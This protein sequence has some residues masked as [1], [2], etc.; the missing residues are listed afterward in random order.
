MAD[1]PIV[2]SSRDSSLDGSMDPV[3]AELWSTEPPAAAPG[4]VSMPLADYVVHPV[5]GL[6]LHEGDD[7]HTVTRE[8][9][10]C[11]QP[12]KPTQAALVD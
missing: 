10:A 5:P 11:K 8:H 7:G 3:Q 2:D 9:I 6:P 1:S 12:L 4:Q